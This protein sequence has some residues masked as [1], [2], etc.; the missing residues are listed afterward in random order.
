LKS[1]LELSRDLEEH[2]IALHRESIV[3]DA[4]IVPFIHHVGEDIWIDDM[5]RGV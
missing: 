4:S 2:A 3:I 5:I 1:G